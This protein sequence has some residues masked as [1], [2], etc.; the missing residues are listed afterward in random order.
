[1]LDVPTRFD[2]MPSSTYAAFCC[3]AMSAIDH[4]RSDPE[5][6]QAPEPAGKDFL[7]GATQGESRDIGATG[8]RPNRS[9]LHH[10]LGRYY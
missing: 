6:K 1:M 2:T 7:N 9:F 10:Y 4:Q 3:R 5:A 8:A